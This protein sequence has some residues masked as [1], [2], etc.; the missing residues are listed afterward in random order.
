M[1]S[2][3]EALEIPDDTATT[4]STPLDNFDLS[5]TPAL[6]LSADEQIDLEQQAEFFLALGQDESAVD[7]LNAS[8]RGGVGSS[9]PTYLKLLEIHRRRGERDAY[10]SIRE[11]HDRRFDDLAPCWADDPTEARGLDDHP[12]VMRRI[13]S[14][15]RGN[16]SSVME[17]IQS[18]IAS[19][20]NAARP[21]DLP[22][23]ADLQFLH[24]LAR[25]VLDESGD[26]P[27]EASAAPRVDLL[28]PLSHINEPRSVV[29][30]AIGSI[31]KSGEGGGAVVMGDSKASDIDLELDFPSPA[32]DPK[33]LQ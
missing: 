19:N 5:P 28:L 4:A 9:Q 30:A 2:L 26:S 15:W 8:V 1:T 25:S 7:L 13:E 17:L 14:A 29:A 33:P 20:E 18:L 23:L 22:A 3:P 32:A 10:E 27:V 6:A 12:E 21:L 11:L 24:Q 16:P 31:R